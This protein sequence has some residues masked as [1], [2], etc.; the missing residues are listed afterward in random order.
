MSATRLLRTPRVLAVVAMLAT[1][2]SSA[3]AFTNEEVARGREVFA[4]CASC[5]LVEGYPS[6]PVM[7]PQPREMFGRDGRRRLV[8]VANMP[9]RAGTVGDITDY[10]LARMPQ[11]APGTL[12]EREAFDVTVFLL[13]SNG[14]VADGQP[15]THDTLDATKAST[16]LPVP[17]ST[18]AMWAGGAAAIAAVAIA[19]WLRRRRR[20]QQR[21]ASP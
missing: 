12:T 8:A 21:R 11:N 13:S 2:A 14:V 6:P 19:F 18:K 1:S 7:A 10:I 20:L 16:V 9:G 17:S 3:S 15:T 4:K 5:H